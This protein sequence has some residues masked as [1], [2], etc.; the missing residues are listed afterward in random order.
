MKKADRKA[1]DPFSS[2]ARN[3]RCNAFFVERLKHIAGRR[4]SFKNG[5]AKFPRDQRLLLHQRQIHR[6]EATFVSDLQDVAKAMSRNQCGSCATALENGIG[7]KSSAVDEPVDIFGANARF[8][9]YLRDPPQHTLLGHGVSGQELPGPPSGPALENDV[10][11]GSTNIC[12]QTGADL[13][14]GRG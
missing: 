12:R 9:Q 4:D 1:F 11:E 2:K 6:I 3:K 13:F 8:Q 14:R 5:E 10:C 7:S